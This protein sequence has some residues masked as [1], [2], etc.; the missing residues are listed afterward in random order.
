MVNFETASNKNVYFFLLLEEL[1][2]HPEALVVAERGRCRTLDTFNDK[3]L[4]VLSQNNLELLGTQRYLACILHDLLYTVWRW[5]RMA[6]KRTEKQN[7]CRTFKLV[8]IS[9]HNPNACDLI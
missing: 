1:G 4:G 8:R 6:K 9:S 7:I 2:R 5:W 3:Q